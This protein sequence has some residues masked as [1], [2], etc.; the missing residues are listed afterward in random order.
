MYART[1][2]YR[3]GAVLVTVAI[4]LPVLI[5]V[6]ALHPGGRRMCDE[7][8]RARAAADASARA[9]GAD[10]YTNYWT[11]HGTDPTESPRAAAAE[12]VALANGDPVPAVTANI[13]PTSGTYSGH[14]AP[15]RRRAR[16]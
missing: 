11:N 9:A 5:G 12:Q 7:R 13:P 1:Q 3:R 2:K 10:L 14:P 8:R 15:R 4:R 6:I 16:R